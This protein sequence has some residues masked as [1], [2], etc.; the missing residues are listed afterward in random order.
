MFKVKNVI[1]PKIISDIFKVSRTTY[2]LRNK[3]DFLSNHVKTV[4]VST[5]SLSYLGPKFWD[6]LPSIDVTNTDQIS[7][8]K[9]FPQNCH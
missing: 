5:E 3:T 4:Y 1:A 8:K 9:W 7:S 2:N 6:L